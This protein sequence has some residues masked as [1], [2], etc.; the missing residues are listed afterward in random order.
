MLQ[1]KLFTAIVALCCVA[2]AKVNVLGQ[3]ETQSFDSSATAEAAGWIFNDEAQND[4]RICQNDELC[5]TDLGWMS[6]NNAG[7]EDAGEGGGLVHRSGGQPIG[8]YGDLS[9]GELNLDMAFSAS[10][11][12]SLTN[13]S[14]NGHYHFGFFDGQ[15][16]LEDP[17]DYGAQVAFFLAEPKGDIRP[18]FR[19]G[20]SVRTDSLQEDAN[21]NGYVI[22]AE[23]DISLDFEISYDPN[24]A[25]ILTMVLGE[26]DELEVEIPAALRED[27]TTLTAFG[28][29]TAPS[30]SNARPNYMEIYLD[31]LTYTSIDGPVGISG[32]YNGNGELDAEDIDI[33]SAAVQGQSTDSEYDLNGDGSVSDADRGTWV[34]STDFKHTWFGDADLDGEFNSTDFVTV[35]TAGQ[36]EDG[37]AGNSGWSTGDWNGD[38]EFDSADFVAAF[39]D[40]GFELGPKAAV[41]AVP[42]PATLG[43]LLIG[44]ICLSLARRRLYR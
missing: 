11:K 10:G 13:V 38:K 19:W 2:L 16:L 14:V 23:P 36:Y 22:G 33:L 20:H 35:F 42:E 24:D 6:S 25:G 29:F 21:H 3:T 1:R 44:F 12:V 7:G 28:V 18:N 26:D 8:F 34:S 27:Q 40:G 41:A 15:R 5:E 39:V 30:P 4:E 31:D 43:S 32:D 37:V 17:L 9:I